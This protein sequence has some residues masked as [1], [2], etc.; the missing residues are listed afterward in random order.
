[1][2]SKENDGMGKA[3]QALLP[4]VKAAGLDVAFYLDQDTHFTQDTLDWLA[5]WLME[6]PEGLHGWGL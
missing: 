3:L 5:H 6:H 2:G 4:A 1:M